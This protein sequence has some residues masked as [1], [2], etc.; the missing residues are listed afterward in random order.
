MLNE[1][2]EALALM[3][4][5]KESYRSHQDKVTQLMKNMETFKESLLRR[6][7]KGDVAITQYNLL[8]E[9]DKGLLGE[10]LVRWK[11]KPLG[12]VFLGE[13]KKNVSDAFDEMIKTE[14]TRNKQ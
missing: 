12:A 3:D 11:E 9:S 10:F 8:M 4:K 6:S 2:Q 14:N 5:G 13:W 1:K 7:P